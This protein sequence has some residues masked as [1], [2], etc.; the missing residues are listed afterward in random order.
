[1]IDEPFFNS[2]SEE[3][4]FGYLQQFVGNMSSDVTQKFL[5]FVTGSSV[6]VCPK[7]DITFNALSGLARRPIAHTCAPLEVPTSYSTYV[8]VALNSKRY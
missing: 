4:V 8:E 5:R 7:I 3:R 2:K 6:A 1:M